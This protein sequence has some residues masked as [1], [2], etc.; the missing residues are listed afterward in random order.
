MRLPAA[1]RPNPAC[2][3]ADDSIPTDAP[4]IAWLLAQGRVKMKNGIRLLSLLLACGE[5]V[6]DRADEGPSH[7]ISGDER[8]PLTLTLSPQA[9]RGD[10]RER[11]LHPT[12]KR[13]QA[14]TNRA[15]HALV[16]PIFDIAARPKSQA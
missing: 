13:P 4:G 6:P 14:L 8:S 11:G 3:G 16:R 7:A 12:R 1:P 10:N 9:G 15:G 2:Q 5:K